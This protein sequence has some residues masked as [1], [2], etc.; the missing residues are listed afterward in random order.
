MAATGY[1]SAKLL[2]NAMRRARS[3]S[4]KDLAAAIAATKD[5]PGVTGII[6]MDE[7]RNARKPAVIL[8]LQSGRP[9]YV[10]TIQ[11]P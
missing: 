8:R 4:G 2:I 9:S 11:P 6:T 3:L 7:Q 5:F 1:D 10:T